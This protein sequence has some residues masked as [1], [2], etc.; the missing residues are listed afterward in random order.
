MNITE[1]NSS[2]VPPAVLHIQRRARVSESHARLIAVL[3]GI[4]LPDAWEHISRPAA[5]A[6][7]AMAWRARR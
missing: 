4:P 6:V 1:I 3:S 5:Q 2:P 7:A